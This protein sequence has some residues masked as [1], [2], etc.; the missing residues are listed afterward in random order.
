MHPKKQIIGI[1]GQFFL[2]LDWDEKSQNIAVFD[3][4]KQTHESRADLITVAPDN[5]N[6][7]VYGMDTH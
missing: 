5:S 3:T 7:F 4:F 2:A 1:F 6:F